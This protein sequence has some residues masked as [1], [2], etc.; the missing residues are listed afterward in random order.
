MLAPAFQM[1]S[2]SIVPTRQGLHP[3]ETHT[4]PNTQ[5]E[6]QFDWEDNRS[7]LLSKEDRGDIPNEE[8]SI[9]ARSLL[10]GHLRTICFILHILLV[11]A[12]IVLL[13]SHLQHWEHLFTFPL[14]HQASIS[15]WTTVTSQAIGTIYTALLLFLTQKLAMQCNF[16]TWQTL[17][18]THDS[19]SSWAGLGSALATLYNQIS[20]PASVFGTF[21]VVG[22]LAC[23]AIL[24]TSIPAI[25]SVGT[26]TAT[27]ALPAGTVG[28]P[29]YENLTA[30][31]STRA[32]MTTF[33]TSFLPWRQIFNDSPIVGLHNNSLY[34]VL[35]STTIAKGSA[36]VT[37]KGFNV[38]CGYIPAFKWEAGIGIQ[39][40]KDTTL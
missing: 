19:I 8:S 35:Q 26:F 38:T 7:Y 6:S 30:V 28:L 22:Y 3:T 2:A 18:A 17:T 29:Q 11:G 5:T 31:N 13:I 36:Q 25:I 12:H 14:E 1:S 24:H 4:T 15:F 37:A 32:F 10:Q 40:I 33:P 21:H 27:V 16:Q 20:V 39:L 34:E 9:Q 23:I